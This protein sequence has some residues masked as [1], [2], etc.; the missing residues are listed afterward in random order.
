MTPVYL[1]LFT[2]CGFNMFEIPGLR[3]QQFLTPLAHISAKLVVAAPE[4]LL[5]EFNEEFVQINFP[6]R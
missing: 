4:T 5:L 6:A 3:R 1:G 2:G